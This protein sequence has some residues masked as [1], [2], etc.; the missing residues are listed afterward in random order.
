MIQT[1]QLLVAAILITAAVTVGVV[2]TQMKRVEDPMQDRG[3]LEKGKE[4]PPL[5]L[6]VDDS[7]VNSRHWMD[8]MARSSRVMNLPFLNL[9]YE[10]IVR[11]NGADYRIEVIGGL[12][13]LA[14]RLG[15]WEALPTPLQNA[16]AL[17]GKPELNWIRAA[18]LA[19]FGGL[20]MQ[21]AMVALAPVGPLPADRITFFGTD[22]EVTVVGP[23]GTATPGLRMAWSPVPGHPLWLDWEARARARLE[24]RA[25]GSEFRRDEM[26]DAALAIRQYGASI[27]IRP[28]AELGRNEAG[29]RIELEQLL[30]GGQEG[31]AP[32]ADCGSAAVLPIPWPEIKER[33]NFGWFLRMS[34]DQILESDLVISAYFRKALL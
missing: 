5:W 27:E 32:F 3:L 16:K 19:E 2:T 1:Q 21:P 31:I 8:F 11:K 6:Y 12:Q 18:V 22:E 10:T 15:G 34:E 33:R 29:R 26:S 9:C 30:A 13:D 23:T 28:D 25:G 17:V 7:E 4:L 24:K 20:W 14:T